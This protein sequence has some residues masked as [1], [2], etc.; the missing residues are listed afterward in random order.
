M[1]ASLLVYAPIKYCYSISWNFVLN[2]E[3]FFR[4]HCALWPGAMMLLKTR[5]SCYVT[6]V[7]TDTHSALSHCHFDATI[8]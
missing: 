3:F 1:D 4:I 2:A 7:N 6:T 5:I 8:S